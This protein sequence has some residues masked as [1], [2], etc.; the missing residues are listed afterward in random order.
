[1][2]VNSF[3]PMKGVV[4][5]EEIVEDA[6]MSDE[7]KPSEEHVDEEDV[8]EHSADDWEDEEEVTL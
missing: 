4:N 6:A 1:M 5:E 8:M 3:G 7:E 2:V